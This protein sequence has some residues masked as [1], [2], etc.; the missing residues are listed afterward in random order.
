M[1]SFMVALLIGCI[2]LMSICLLICTLI[3]V[4]IIG[5]VNATKVVQEI[6]EWG[7]KSF[8]EMKRIFQM[9][10]KVFPSSKLRVI[11]VSFN[12]LAIVSLLTAVVLASVGNHH[13]R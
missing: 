6:P 1:N 9:H 3:Y 5:Q 7:R 2:A 10:R 8:P 4:E 13:L 11:A 12:C